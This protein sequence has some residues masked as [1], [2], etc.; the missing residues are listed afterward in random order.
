MELIRKNFVLIGVIIVIVLGATWYSLSKN[1]DA[2]TAIETTEGGVLSAQEGDPA[3]EADPDVLRLLL[4]MRAIKLDGRLFSSPAFRILQ[5]TGKDI[6]KEPTGR[7]N[8]FAPIGTENAGGFD[9]D[10]S[11]GAQEN[12]QSGRRQPGN[13]QQFTE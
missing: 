10:A 12:Q 1:T 6:I 5:D 3:A 4:D 2:N 13:I 7:P 11:S 8:P 9:I